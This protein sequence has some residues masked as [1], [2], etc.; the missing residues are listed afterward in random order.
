MVRGAEKFLG[1]VKRSPPPTSPNGTGY[2]DRKMKSLTVRLRSSEFTTSDRSI[3][4]RLS[5]VCFSS[6]PRKYGYASSFRNES[7]S[8]A[9]LIF[10]HAPTMRQFFAVLSGL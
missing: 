1:P 3:F 9:D 10:I 6:S 8:K 4:A 5:V 7:M 2:D